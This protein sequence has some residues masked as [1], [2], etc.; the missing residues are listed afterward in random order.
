M[1]SYLEVLGIIF[2]FYCIQFIVG[3]IKKN[4]SIVDIFWGLGFVIAVLFACI[5]NA[6][7]GSASLLITT[8]V[9]IWGLRLTKHIGKRN[10]GK[11]EDF[12][13][14]NF[15]KQW[16]NKWVKLKAFLHVYMLQMLMMLLISSASLNIIL[17]NRQTLTGLDYLGI[18][19]W[20]IGFFFEARSDYELKRFKLD[21]NN[22][23]TIMMEG[24]F[25]YTRHPNYFGEATMWWGIYLIGLSSN[26]WIYIVSPL[27]IT[28]LMRYVSGVPM[29]EKH[30]ENNASFQLYAKKTSIFVPWFPRK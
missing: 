2:I 7:Y 17:D 4:N 30:Y 9:S 13:Y 15:R 26:G 1:N 10:R 23:G 19:I 8:L 12:R 6:H 21:K 20:C 27:T 16:G 22:K 28:I 25:K 11:S 14:V 18:V 24:L 5:S 3:Q 29:L